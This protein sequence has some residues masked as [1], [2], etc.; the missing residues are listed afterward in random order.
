MLARLGVAK[1]CNIPNGTDAPRLPALADKPIMGG[2][3]RLIIVSRLEPNKRVGDA[4]EVLSLLC[5]Q[6]IDASLKIV[7]SGS[8]AARLGGRV[9]ALG[10]SGRVCFTGRVTDQEKFSLLQQAHILIHTSVREGWGLN[11]IEANAVGTP[12]IVYPVAGLVD[13]TVNGETGIVTAKEAPGEI[14]RGVRFLIE[15]PS[16]YSQMRTSAWA[17]SKTFDWNVI[18]PRI[19]QWLEA[20]ARGGA[21]FESRGV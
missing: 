5:S 12:A 16:V 10:L 17:R 11:V 13:S 14:A 4:I 8:E 19:C 1:V 6:G 9:E 18:A 21:G 15:N 2:A 7:G 20:E 3:V